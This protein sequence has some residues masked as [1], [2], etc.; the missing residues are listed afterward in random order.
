[1]N[2][3]KRN[4]FVHEP[5]TPGQPLAWIADFGLSALGEATTYITQSNYCAPEVRERAIN[6]QPAYTLTTE[7][8]ALYVQE[9]IDRAGLMEM[10]DIY[11]FGWTIFAVSG[12]FFHKLHRFSRVKYQMLTGNSV[13]SILQPE[14]RRVGNLNM[15]LSDAQLTP[16]VKDLIRKC[17]R[18]NPSGRPAMAEVRRESQEGNLAPLEEIA[19]RESM[20][21]Y[22]AKFP[23]RA[24]CWEMA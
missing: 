23:P 15:G 11:S 13:P 19:N 14:E 8:R 20:V 6:L 4:I 22:R 24:I 1:M 5:Q 10:A 21:S 18:L 2:L 9:R 17:C 16:N 3:P 12:R 7:E